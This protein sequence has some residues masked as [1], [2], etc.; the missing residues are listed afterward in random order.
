MLCIGAQRR[1]LN[2]RACCVRRTS[3]LFLDI[4]PLSHYTAGSEKGKEIV[5]YNLLCAVKEDTDAETVAELL[6]FLRGQSRLIDRAVK[7]KRSA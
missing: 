6:Q 4:W 1:T 5:Q 2:D 7:M 3:G